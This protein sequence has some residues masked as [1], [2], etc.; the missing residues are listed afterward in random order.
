V[1][2]NGNK[3]GVVTALIRAI[4]H[5]GVQVSQ[6]QVGGVKGLGIGYVRL[7]LQGEKVMKKMKMKIKMKKRRRRRRKLG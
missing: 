7:R 4:I 5:A 6:Y 1:L 3:R 2:G